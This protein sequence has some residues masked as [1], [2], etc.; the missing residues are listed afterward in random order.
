M[1]SLLAQSHMLTETE[2]KLLAEMREALSR[3][4]HFNFKQF[5]SWMQIDD[6]FSK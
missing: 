1:G 6:I 4:I 3:G 5:V 2:I